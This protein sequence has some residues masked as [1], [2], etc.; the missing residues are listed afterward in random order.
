MKVSLNWLRELVDLPADVAAL[1]DL[2]TQA[3]VEVEG[4]ETRGADFDN[5]VIAHILESKP[6]PN[7]DRLSVCQ[8]EDGSGQPRQ[9]VCGAKNYKVGDKVP[10]ALPGA[11]LPGDFRIKVGKLRGVQSEGMMCSARE[12]QLAEDADGLLILP[13]EARVGAPIGSLFPP[14]TV[15]E[16]EVTPNRPDLLSHAGMAREI[17]TL[18]GR[19]WRTPEI[20]AP[21]AVEAAGETVSIEAPDACPFY[22]AR[23][24]TGVKVGPS[25]EWLRLRLESAGLRAI[26]NIV[27]ITNYVMLELGQPLHAFDAAKLR[28]GI[29]VRNAREAESFLALDGKTYTLNPRHLV[30]AD[31][32]EALAIAGVMGGEATGV[33]EATTEVLLESAFFC[34]TRV[35]RT[36][37]ELALSS[38]SSYRFERRV[39]PQGVAR[40]SARAVELILE[41]AGGAAEPTL[42]LA[43][44]IPAA[45]GLV[46]LRQERV[47]AILGADVPETRVEQI[48]TGFGL[49]REASGWRVPSFRA[50][51]EREI[52]LIEEIARVIGIDAVPSREI[53]R[54]FGASDADRRHDAAMRIRHWLAGRGL[55]EVR[56]LTLISDAACA[57]FPVEAVLRV[58]NPLSED[59]G[60]LRPGLLPGLLG[61]V[62]LNIRNGNRDLRLFEVGR[63]FAPATGAEG[64]EEETRAA[65]VITGAAAPVSWR[66][67]APRD[68]DFFDLKGLLESLPLEGLSFEPATHP[69]LALALEIRQDGDPVGLIGQLTP[70]R[71]RAL[72]ASGPVLVAELTLDALRTEKR[73]LRAAE[74]PRFPGV[75]RD[76]AFLAAQSVSHAAVEAVLR[77][78]NEPL[79]AG[80]RLFDVFR[81]E[82]GQKVAADQ[83]SLAYSLTY[84]SGERTLTAEE[85]AT[86]HEKLKA[87]LQSEL[88]VRFR[89]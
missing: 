62:T 48:L 72:D 7:A 29:R 70:A 31:E 36:S 46:P 19:P 2:L 57:R 22:T 66:D 6:H 20:T 59:E 42:R 35:R 67:T 3:G 32:A 50:D 52:D 4:V 11:V 86:V 5:V 79:L 25:P 64:R 40:A 34:P 85:V 77:A 83:K 87:R 55:R 14:D 12:L 17:A 73:H 63:V 54:Y 75:S 10:L 60:I 61:N 26:N 84:R 39:D 41:L 21:V 65:L 58:R 71:A 30:I 56:N 18:L 49:E 89:E 80:V 15:L 44:Q 74:L 23:R 28:G 27:D 9:I 78:A 69:A 76:I 51:L 53:T 33:T 82:S 8:V 88:G 38:D 68:A 1:S 43:G 24:I 13:P 37:R 47:R 81:D 16:V 45:P